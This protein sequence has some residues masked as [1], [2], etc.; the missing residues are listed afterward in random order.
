MK[1]V[2]IGIFTGE[3]TYNVWKSIPYEGDWGLD[4]QGV[5]VHRELQKVN[6]FQE[7][8][9]L[10]Q[11][12]N[13]NKKGNPVYVASEY[14]HPWIS[15]DNKP[16]W[17][18]KQGKHLHL[19]DSNLELADF[20]FIKNFTKENIIIKCRNGA[21]ILPSGEIMITESNKCLNNKRNSDNY[22][23]TKLERGENSRRIEVTTEWCPYCGEDVEI[24]ST[25]MTQCKCG[26]WLVP[27]SMCNMDNADCENCVSSKMA[28]EKNKLISN[29]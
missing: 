10:A 15:D 21:F 18:Y 22:R 26:K 6:N 4:Y 13:N 25:G 17:D 11:K 20:S 16:Y 12:M 2:L 5:E 23:I 8:S 29:K 27:C 3:E 9:K 7:F 28:E 14:H 19:F 1:G 24:S